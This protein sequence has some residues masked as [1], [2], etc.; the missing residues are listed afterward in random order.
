MLLVKIAAISS[1]ISFLT[2]IMVVGSGSHFQFSKKDILRGRRDAWLYIWIIFSSIF[3]LLHFT[4]L[5]NYGLVYDWQYRTYDTGLW[6]CIH[7]GVGMLLTAAHL[8][9][10][11]DLKK[12]TS[13]YTYIWGT[14]S[15]AR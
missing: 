7:T 12:G 13:S 9:I 14:R 4:S 2:G 15:R 5:I 1:L 3:A 11:G 10:H 8:F 6:M